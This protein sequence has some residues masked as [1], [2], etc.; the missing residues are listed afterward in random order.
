MNRNPHH[1]FYLQSQKREA[2]AN[3]I[4][5]SLTPQPCCDIIITDFTISFA[6]LHD[7][8]SRKT[9]VKTCLIELCTEIQW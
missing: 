8:Y 4:F 7:K 3:L 5:I 6:I 9:N 1:Q 2:I